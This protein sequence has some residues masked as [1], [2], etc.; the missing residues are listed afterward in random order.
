MRK[1]EQNQNAVT[2]KVILFIHNGDM[3]DQFRK[4]F[5]SVSESGKFN[6][7]FVAEEGAKKFFD[8]WKSDI[9]LIVFSEK[10]LGFK[11]VFQKD[12]NFFGEI[13]VSPSVEDLLGKIEEIII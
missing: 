11:S 6:T 13:L 2:K 7:V 3:E 4:V 12:S 9:N 10:N 8:A 1:T 5:S